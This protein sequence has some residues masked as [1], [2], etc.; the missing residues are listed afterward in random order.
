[1]EGGVGGCRSP[2]RD[3]LKL[4][5]RVVNPEEWAK[6]APLSTAE[7][8]LLYNYNDKPLL[9]R[10]Q[11]KFF[12]GPNYLEIDV[13][14]HSYAYLA[15]RAFGAFIPRLTSV[16]F[17]NAFVIQARP[18]LHVCGRP[19]PSA[20]ELI[21]TVIKNKKELFYKIEIRKDKTS[22]ENIMT[23]GSKRAGP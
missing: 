6:E 9:T 8:K 10:P 11:H 21:M 19:S 20:Q 16:V 5:P 17:E 15:R 4:I 13:D 12:H 2:T 18:L 23:G 7:A 22:F 1:M 3:R 14:V